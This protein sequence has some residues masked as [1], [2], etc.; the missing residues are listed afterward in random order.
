M[1]R[2]S[3]PFGSPFGPF[4][5]SLDGEEPWIDDEMTDDP[6]PQLREDG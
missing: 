3:S 6:D 4:V 2:T 1:S 5:T